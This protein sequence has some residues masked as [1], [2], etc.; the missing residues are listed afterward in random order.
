MISSGFGAQRT[1]E[2]PN[3]IAGDR[4]VMAGSRSFQVESCTAQER[5]D[6]CNG[7]PIETER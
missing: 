7:R 3:L 4:P 1:P 5:G 6:N 2:S